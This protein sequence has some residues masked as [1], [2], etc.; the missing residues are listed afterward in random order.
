MMQ[1][2]RKSMQVEGNDLLSGIVEMDETYIGGKPRKDNKQI[3]EYNKGT[4]NKRGKGSNKK[5]VLGMVQREGDVKVQKSN[6]F[7]KYEVQEMIANYMDYE[8][9]TLITDECSSYKK[10]GDFMEHKVIKHKEE[11]C[12]G[13]IHTNTI[14]G[15]WSIVKR[16]ITGIYHKVSFKYL[17]DYLQEFA[18]KYNNRHTCKKELFYNSIINMV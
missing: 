18:Y 10:V 13:K 12:K 8:R 7:N 4:F 16:G 17:D 2:I 3:S 11:F 6:N 5:T 1:R 14:E 15:F 9:S